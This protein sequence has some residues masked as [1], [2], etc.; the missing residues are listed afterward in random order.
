VPIDPHYPSER[1]Y[2][3]L[4]DSDSMML[5][6]TRATEAHLQINKGEY[7]KE[8][9]YVEDELNYH[10]D[11]SNLVGVTKPENMAYLIYTSGSTGKPKGVMIEHRGYVNAAYA[12]MQ[13]YD[14]KQ[15][16]CRLL[17]MASFSFDVFA[18][19][20]AKALLTG[21]QLIICPED[22]RIHPPALYEFMRKHQISVVDTTPAL[23][24]PIMQYV[25]EEGLELPDLKLILLGADTVSIKDFTYLL[26][27]FGQAI[28]ILNTYG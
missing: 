4:T 10:P 19:D 24:V 26:Q 28:R 15:T 16:P 25:A 8:I 7:T 17:Q 23:F 2:Y 5:L 22:I 13:E 27:K 20:M 18:G 3:L 11:G 6:T 14:L 1:I 21:G 12:W 9:L